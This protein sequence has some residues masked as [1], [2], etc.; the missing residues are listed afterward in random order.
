MLTLERTFSLEQYTRDGFTGPFRIMSE[1]QAAQL[2]TVFFKEIGQEEA[3][4]GPTKA[5]FSA[6]HHRLPW[7]Y[8]LAT[9]PAVL[10]AMERI[11]GPDLIMWA[12]HFWYKEPGSTKRIPWHQD[13]AYWPMTP[14]KNVSAWFALGPTFRA[15]GCLRLVPGSHTKMLEHEKLND[16]NSAF[17]QGLKKEFIDESKAVD[18]EM[19]PGEVV[20]FNEATFHGSEAN[21]STTPR[22]ACSVRYTTPEVK[23]LVEQWGDAGRIKTFL[24]RGKDERHLN[25]AIVGEKPQV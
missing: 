23:F 25:D 4:A 10:D 6:W 3:Q 13:G 12:M 11:L 15:N 21:T 8:D 2:R 20:I 17:G 1:E 22:V 14:V 18:I 24:V 9:N 16:A 7:C 5:Y 19:R